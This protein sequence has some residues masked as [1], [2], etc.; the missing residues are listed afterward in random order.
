MPGTPY[1]GSDIRRFGA[2]SGLMKDSVFRLDQLPRPVVLASLRETCA[3]RVCV[4]TEREK[5]SNGAGRGLPK[6][7]GTFSGL[8]PGPSLAV[9]AAHQ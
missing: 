9:A 1:A 8:R 7:H 5:G 2:S 3:Y 6:M 4:E